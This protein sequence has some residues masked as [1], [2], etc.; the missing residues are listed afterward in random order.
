MSYRGGKV[1]ED[2]VNAALMQAKV[3]SD[4]VTRYFEILLAD[5][6]QKKCITNSKMNSL[7]VGEQTCIDRC[8]FKYWEAHHLVSDILNGAQKNESA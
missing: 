4:F 2:N 6:C 3:L 5:T 8:T 7:E 1:N